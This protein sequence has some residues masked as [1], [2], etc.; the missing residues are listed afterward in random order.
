M[1]KIDNFKSFVRRNPNLIT[2][3]RERILR[4]R[5]SMN[6]MIYMGK[7]LLSGINT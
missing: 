7:I 6:Y 1:T 5:S 2:Y 4:G 3:V